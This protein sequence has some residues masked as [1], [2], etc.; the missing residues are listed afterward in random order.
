[1]FTKYY[2][3]RW[4][5]IIYP[6][7]IYAHR[8]G[9]HQQNNNHSADV[10]F[11]WR[12]F[13]LAVSPDSTSFPLFVCPPPDHRV[14]QFL[15]TL[16]YLGFVVLQWIDWFGKNMIYM[17][18]YLGQA[19]DDYSNLL[20]LFT[21]NQSINSYNVPTPAPTGRVMKFIYSAWRVS[22]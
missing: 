20:I 17:Y 13:R 7:L 19:C 1:M 5:F 12:A 18:Q 16:V 14:V 22:L 11:T 2:I 10:C 3:K 9:N 15:K 6:P 21:V 4:P 8:Y